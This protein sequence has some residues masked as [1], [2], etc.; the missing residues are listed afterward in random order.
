L[1]ARGE[2]LSIGSVRGI[3]AVIS[4]LKEVMGVFRKREN[5]KEGQ[6]KQ[7]GKEEEEEEDRH[8]GRRGVAGA[9]G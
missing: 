8:R 3:S 9:G 5:F 4:L 6:G 1:E 7:F 2:R